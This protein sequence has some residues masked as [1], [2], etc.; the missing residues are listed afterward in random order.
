[1]GERFGVP[2]RHY[3]WV[4]RKRTSLIGLAAAVT[5]AGVSLIG[6]GVGANAT[7]DFFPR[8][9]AALTDVSGQSPAAGGPN[10]TPSRP[11]P[12]AAARAARAKRVSALDTA[13]KGYTAEAP[14]FAEYSVAVLDRRTGARYAY[15]GKEKYE[16]ASIVK[17][18]VLACLLL[19]AQ[20]DERELT[21]EEKRLAGLMIRISDNDATTALFGRLGR[22]A[23]ISRCN[24][25]L[26]L[27]ATTVSSS[28][29]L[30]RTTVEDQ[31]KLLAELVDPKGP[32]DADSREFAHALM[33]T[34]DNDQDW[35]VSAA[36]EPGET[37]ALK[38]GWLD[39]PNE[40]GR[41]AVNSVGRI[42]GDD[43]TDVS[44]SVLSHGNATE[45]A[46]QKLVED[47]AEL[48]RE[49]LRY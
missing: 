41:W 22:V 1:M 26:G 44:V 10:P 23:A 14:E 38:N 17:V 32:L 2:A 29:G 19:D 28:W 35:G 45:E 13:L 30:T 3:A 36:A 31:V 34:V 43:G 5:V 9:G 15:R 48:T 39:R 37:I 21:A 27:A 11:D 7:D 6:F 8:V 33:T 20:D 4:L 47:V 42:T 18:Q 46:G 24:K 25:R 40:G 49:H 16:T 12:E